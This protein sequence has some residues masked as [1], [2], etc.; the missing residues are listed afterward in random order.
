MSRQKS[1]NVELKIHCIPDDIDTTRLDISAAH[2][3]TILRCSRVNVFVMT[4]SKVLSL[5]NPTHDW[6]TDKYRTLSTSYFVESIIVDDLRI[7]N[8]SY[9]P[10]QQWLGMEQKYEK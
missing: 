5:L 10:S 4:V 7:K 2:R 8:R 9:L 6:L 3:H 1:G